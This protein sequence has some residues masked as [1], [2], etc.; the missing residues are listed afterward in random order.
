MRVSTL[1]VSTPPTNGSDIPNTQPTASGSTHLTSSGVDSF[2]VLSQLGIPTHMADCNDRGLLVAYQNYKAYLDVCHI[3]EVKV[4]DGSWNGGKLTGVDLIKLF[5]LKLF[6]HS[7]LRFLY[8]C[9]I[10]QYV[11]LLMLL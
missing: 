10:T 6:W 1:G 3:Y 7:L 11:Y 4:A 2:E 5:I 9:L 8:F